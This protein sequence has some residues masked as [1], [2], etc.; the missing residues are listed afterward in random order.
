MS[1][2]TTVSGRHVDPLH[3]DPERI[4]LQD[5]AHALSLVCRAN[6]HTRCFYSVAQ[7]SINCCREAKA[8]GD[9]LIVQQACLLHDSAEA[10]LCDVTRPIKEHL[11]GYQAQESRLLDLIWEKYL[12]RPLTG[13]ERKEVFRIDDDM[14]SYEFHVLMPESLSE[15]YKKIL[16]SPDTRL[17]DPEDVER[18]FLELCQR[19]KTR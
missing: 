6:G 13:E 8:R 18:E 4:D 16:S 9:S 11:K 5:I 17:R 7:H 2:I 3:P 12:G 15:D 1:T 10:Y 14:L 19:L